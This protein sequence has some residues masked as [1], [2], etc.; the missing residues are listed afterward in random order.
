MMGFLMDRQT[1]KRGKTI[2][3]VTLI[4]EMCIQGIYHQCFKQFGPMSQTWRSV[5]SD[6]VPNCLQRLSEGDTC[7]QGVKNQCLNSIHLDNHSV[8]M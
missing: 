6:L 1:D 5:R 7:K 4:L 2:C 8:D 3:L